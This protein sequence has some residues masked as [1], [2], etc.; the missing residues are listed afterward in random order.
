[1]CHFVCFGS[2]GLCFVFQQQSPDT[3]PGPSTGPA[4]HKVRKHSHTWKWCHTFSFAVK[5]KCVCLIPTQITSVGIL[6]E[7][8][9]RLISPTTQTRAHTHTHTALI[10]NSNMCVYSTLKTSKIKYHT[11]EVFLSTPGKKEPKKEKV[12]QRNQHLRRSCGVFKSKSVTCAKKCLYLP[13]CFA[14]QYF[15]FFIGCMSLYT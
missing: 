14:P 7:G 12:K 5:Q 11:G 9:S 6:P 8:I 3:I 13:G 2:D 15:V 1:M 10:W 4:V